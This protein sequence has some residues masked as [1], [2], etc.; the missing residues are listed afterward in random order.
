MTEAAVKNSKNRRKSRVGRAVLAGVFLILAAAGTNILVAGRPGRLVVDFL[1]VGQGD[2]A[3]IRTPSGQIILIDGG[4]DNKILRRLGERL[5]FY[6]RRIDYVLYSHYHADHIT[7]LVGVMK[8][9]EVKN[10]IYAPGAHSSSLLETLQQTATAAGVAIQPI[11]GTAKINF[12][13]DC[14]LNLLNPEILG[15]APDENNSLV[16]ALA[17]AGRTFLFSGDNNDKVEKALLAFTADKK[18]CAQFVCDLHVE[19]FKAS[20]HGSNTANSAEFLRAVRPQLMVISV[21]ADNRFGHPHPATLERAASLGIT[22]RRTDR[23]GSVSVA[24]P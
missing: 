23:D 21:G 3:L 5:P 18:I 7:G 16:A 1:D 19:I 13:P 8:W 20:H 4:P 17:C 12:G 14:F 10:L 9:Y 6:R 24:G 11:V 15:V 22:V 2:A